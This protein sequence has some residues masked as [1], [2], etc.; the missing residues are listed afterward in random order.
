M[1]SNAANTRRFSYAARFGRGGSFARHMVK[2]LMA[3]WMMFGMATSVQAEGNVNQT[4]EKTGYWAVLFSP[5][6]ANSTATSAAVV[7]EAIGKSMTIFSWWHGVFVGTSPNVTYYAGYEA[8]DCL[9][10]DSETGITAIQNA[11]YPVTRGVCPANSTPGMPCTCDAGYK[12]DPTIT[13]CIPVVQYTIALHN[14][15]VGGELAP[16]ASR[17]AYAQVM[18]GAAAKSGIAV[19][20][21]TT[22]PP[23]AGTAILS[24]TRGSTGGDGRLNFTFTAPPVGGTHTITATCDGGKCTN[25]ATETIV[26]S[27]C[28]VSPLTPMTEQAALDFENPANR[29]RPD[30]LT[31]DYPTKLACVQNAITAAGGT[32][33]GT[34][35]YRPTQYQQHLFEIVAKDL[36]LDTD[37]MGD[38]PEC[39]TLRD[40]ITRKMGPEPQGHALKRGQDVAIPGTSRHESGTAFDLTPI[41]LSKAQMKPIYAGCGVTNTKVK[42]EPWHVQ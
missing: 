21:T 39:Q 17:A 32:Y 8:L 29:W 1:H 9:F 16:S 18:E 28:T 27:A 3:A 42:S 15:N 25:Q 7:C 34:S 5:F 38:H 40:E 37:F 20:L 12:P 2:L 35:A 26:V 11:V 10:R 13:K 6:A 24:P 30:G 19:T 23:E 4:R 31:G 22:A 14:L 36:K 33:V 41:G